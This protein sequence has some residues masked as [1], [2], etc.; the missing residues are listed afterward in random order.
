MDEFMTLTEA[1]EILNIDRSAF[2]R[3]NKTG[4]I[5]LYKKGTRTLVKT[6]DVYRLKLESEEI[7]PLK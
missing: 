6:D 7:K 3:W 4:K 5:T 2:Y 1:A